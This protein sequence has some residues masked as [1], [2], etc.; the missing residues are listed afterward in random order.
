MVVRFL[1]IVQH[2]ILPKA[3]SRSAK[4]S[5]D[6]RSGALLLESCGRLSLTRKAKPSAKKAV[7]QSRVELRDNYDV[8]QT[9]LVVEDDVVDLVVEL[10]TGGFPGSS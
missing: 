9:I 5:I 8:G 4:T 1:N 7:V 10:A 3:D 2:V 6:G